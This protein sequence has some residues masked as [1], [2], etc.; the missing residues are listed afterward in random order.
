MVT[1]VRVGMEW[2]VLAERKAHGTPPAVWC[3]GLHTSTAGVWVLSLVR[4]LGSCMK[5]GLAKR[6]TNLNVVIMM[7]MTPC[8]GGG[9]W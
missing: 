7:G 5:Y 3:L 9:W 2:L 8:Y 6:K 4:G 1:A